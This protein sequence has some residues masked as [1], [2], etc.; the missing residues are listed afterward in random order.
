MYILKQRTNK[1]YNSQ[2]TDI[3]IS[4]NN[5]SEINTNEILEILSFYSDEI[6]LKRFTEDPSRLEVAIC[7][8]IKSYELLITIKE[9]LFAKFPNLSINYV[10][11]SLILCI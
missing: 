3:I 6:N 11:H 10:Y 8:K 5:P 4:S 7:M 2:L 1:S 9:Q